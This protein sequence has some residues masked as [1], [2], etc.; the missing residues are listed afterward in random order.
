MGGWGGRRLYSSGVVQ[1]VVLLD[2]M[3]VF[4]EFEFS[5]SL[6]LRPLNKH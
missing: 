5:K 4:G 3:T 2:K 6:L 1:V